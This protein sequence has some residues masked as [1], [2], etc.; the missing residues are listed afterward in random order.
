MKKIVHGGFDAVCVEAYARQFGL[1]T[2][3]PDLCNMPYDEFL[4]TD[5][6]QA[7]RRKVLEDRGFTC[8]SC[9]QETDHPHIHHKR[10]VNRGFELWFPEDLIVLCP[11]CHQEVHLVWQIDQ[12][13]GRPA[14][15]DEIILETNRLADLRARTPEERDQR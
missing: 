6:W 3:G 8:E 2:G 10:Y 4:K 12:E 14:T 15:Q 1:P 9:R 13:P 11:C 5:Y 7:V